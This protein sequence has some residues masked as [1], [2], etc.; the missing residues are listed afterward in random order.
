MTY[1]N[2]RAGVYLTLAVGVV[3]LLVLG[4]FGAAK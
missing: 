2:V 1:E 4:I 3:L